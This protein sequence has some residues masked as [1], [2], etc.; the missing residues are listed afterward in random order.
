MKI[1]IKTK[2]LVFLY[3]AVILIFSCGVSSDFEEEIN[4]CIDTNC[5][6]YISQAAAQ[7]AFNAAP[8]CRGDLDA[9]N[10]G[11]ACEEPGNSI[12]TCPPTANCGCSGI[13]KT[14]C[15]S[16]PCCRW[17]VGEGCKCK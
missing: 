13:N 10:D 17:V 11:I 2:A 5:S 16:S 6:D 1:I 9:D 3:L 8:N 12:T 4:P 15:E 14:P 7:S